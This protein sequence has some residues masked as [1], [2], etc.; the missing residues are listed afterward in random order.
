MV[1]QPFRIVK[2]LS[3]VSEPEALLSSG[4]ETLRGQI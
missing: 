1:D 3:K 4:Q 2:T